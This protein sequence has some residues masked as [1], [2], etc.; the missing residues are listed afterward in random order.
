MS[1]VMVPSDIFHPVTFTSLPFFRSL[2]ALFLNSVAEEVKMVVDF[3]VIISTGHV[4]V[5]ESIFP[6]NST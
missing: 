5:R 6:D 1:A 4:P 3:T 2:H